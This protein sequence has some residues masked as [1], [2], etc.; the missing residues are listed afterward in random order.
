MLF[1]YPHFLCFLTLYPLSGSCAPLDDFQE[2]L[3]AWLRSW[4]LLILVILL[5][6]FL[7]LL[8]LL[9][10]EKPTG[11]FSSS[12]Q[13]WEHV[14]ICPPHFIVVWHMG[15]P[16]PQGWDI[17]GKLLSWKHAT[18][19]PLIKLHQSKERK[20]NKTVEV[21]FLETHWHHVAHVGR[22]RQR[23]WKRG[24]EHVG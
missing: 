7:L 13:V 6:I 12:I 16:L 22:I 5:V 15:W 10:L 4:F 18:P 24:N 2:L 3:H 20:T 11:Q 8:L 14:P 9:H 17:A 19:S 21:Q 1:Y 23:R